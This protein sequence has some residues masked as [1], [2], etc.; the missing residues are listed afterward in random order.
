MSS[1]LK[2]QENIQKAQVFL[3]AAHL[4]Q[5]S[6]IA[7][8]ISGLK[9]L[10]TESNEIQKVMSDNLSGMNAKLNEQNQIN[11]ILKDEN[12][13]DNINQ[14]NTFITNHSE[15]VD[16]QLETLKILI[17]KLKDIVNE[18][19]KLKDEK[20]EYNELIQSSDAIEIS[21]KMKEIKKLKND[22]SSFLELNGI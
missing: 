1:D 3:Q 22:I 15:N 8:E 20:K 16:S 18:N 9:K 7:K 2:K 11:S 10:Q 14:I 13:Q 19:N 21:N 5:T 17:P 6:K 12:F 4:Y